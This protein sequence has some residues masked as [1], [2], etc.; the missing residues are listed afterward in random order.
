MTPPFCL[1]VS[2]SLGA[3][4]M[5]FSVLPLQKYVCMPCLLHM[6]FMLS[7]MPFVQGMIMFSLYLFAGFV[8]LEA[9]GLF[10]CVLLCILL[11]TH[12]GYLHYVSPS[13]RYC[14]SFASSSG[15]E[16]TV[17]GPVMNMPFTLY[18]GHKLFVRTFKQSIYI[19]ANNPNFNRNRGKYYLTYVGLTSVYHART[20]NIRTSR[21]KTLMPSAS[22]RIILKT[23][24]PVTPVPK[25]NYGEHCWCT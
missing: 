23:T 21:N 9:L 22:R 17:F 14:I 24:F 6:L 5:F 10:N 4:N 19:R 2:L 3:N 8:L 11:R 12:H 18:F 7:C 16:Q 13:C 20:Q 15:V 25:K 1:I